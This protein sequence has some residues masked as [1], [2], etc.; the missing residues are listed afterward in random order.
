[1]FINRERELAALEQKWQSGVA[2]FFVLYGRR[3]VGKTAL[4]Q[5]FCKNKKSIYFL[6]SQLKEKDHLQQLTSAARHVIDDPLLQSLIFSDWEAA[7]VYFA[8]KAQDERLV[9]VLD[10]FQYLCEDNTALPSLLQRFWDLH[11]K[12]SKLFLILC[13]SQVSFMER[14]VLAS[15]S[16][17]Y[18]RRTG[19]QQL[20]PLSYRDSGRFFP[21]YS[22][23]EKICAYGILGGVP[24]Y[25]NRFDPQRTLE[26]NIKEELLSVTSYL[27]D[28][29]NFLLRMELRDPRTYASLLH[30]VASGR[31]RLSEIAQRVGLDSTTANKYLTVLRDLGLVRRETSVTERAP[32]KSR[33]GLYKIADNYVNFWFRFVLPNRS[34][35]ESGNA[36]MVYQQ[37]IA[38][39]FSHYM[40]GVFEE[41][42]RQYVSRHWN[43]KLEVAP[44]RVGAHWASGLDI[45][46]LTENVD[47]SHFFGECKWWDKPVGEN[48]LNHLIE[49]SKKVPQRW[50]R[51]VQYLLFAAGGFTLELLQRA[52]KEGVFLIEAKEMF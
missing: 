23:K 1:M 34:F 42:C 3:R 47:G 18:G 37:L 22:P 17:L 12:N 6:A 5:Q 7:F 11:G 26:Q 16:P 51:N 32:E 24:A 45:D 2:G 4:L 36:S 28:E 15:K 8:Q 44:K 14:E 30:A 29:V 20:M 39:H 48:V 50:R 13:G 49:I 43:L 10:E 9:L 25:L 40:G 31:A 19:Q 41:V 38:P 27:F 52:E 21:E 46:V 33:K 35:I